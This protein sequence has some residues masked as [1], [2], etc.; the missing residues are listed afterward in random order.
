MLGRHR[1]EFSPENIRD[2]AREEIHRRLQGQGAMLP[3]HE[4]FLRADGEILTLE[5]Q[6]QLLTNSRGEVV[7]L[8]S[9]T[10]DTTEHTHKEQE[11][12]QA[13]SELKA[14]FQALPDTFLRMDVSGTVLD[15][16][17]PE[18]EPIPLNA[19][20]C[21]GRHVS[22]LFTSAIGTLLQET[23]AKGIQGRSM[24]SVNYELTDSRGMRHF[25]ARVT[26]LQ[27]KEVL[28]VIRDIT[29]RQIAEQQL[30]QSAEESATQE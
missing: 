23:A 18:G 19:I 24:C 22:Q 6:E 1:A 8:R 20:N 7:G 17:T 28:V 4:N 12:K 5:I 15:F 27:W 11:I 14:I 10:V 25:E 29:Q 26:A 16:R 3:Y 13:T 9:V 21:I 30:N 2:K